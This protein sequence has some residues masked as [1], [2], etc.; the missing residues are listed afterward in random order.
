MP[1]EDTSIEW[2]EAISPFETVADIRLPAQDFDSPEQN[3]DC[4]NLS[5]NPW[6]ALPEH[7]PIGG[8]N[9]LRKAVYESIS[10]YRLERNGAN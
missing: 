4:D 8:I 9:R 3:I 6:H 2:D 5:F 1:I 7:R 10:S